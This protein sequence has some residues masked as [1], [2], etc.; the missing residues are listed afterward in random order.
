[1]ESKSAPNAG[2]DESEFPIDFTES[3]SSIDI[4]NSASKKQSIESDSS[5]DDNHSCELNGSNE[6]SSEL[7]LAT[8]ASIK[9]SDFVYQHCLQ[10]MDFDAKQPTPSRKPFEPRYFLQPTT[11][12]IYQPPTS[13]K[14]PIKP[15]SFVLD[16][17]PFLP[18][19]A[20]WIP[21]KEHLEHLKDWAK[22]E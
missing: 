4:H 8:Q 2:N 22:G 18:T 6:S 7:D 16:D 15:A 14:N 10:Y 13:E 20:I 12:P 11:G 9:Q 5:R 19:V 17:G 1:M 3:N 21:T